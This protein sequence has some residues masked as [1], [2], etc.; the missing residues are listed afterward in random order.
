MHQSLMT[1]II[2][3]IASQGKIATERNQAIDIHKNYRDD[4]CGLNKEI[5]EK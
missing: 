4:F 3:N 5:S 1:E 2:K